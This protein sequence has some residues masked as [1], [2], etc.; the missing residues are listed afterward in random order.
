[1]PANELKPCP[2]CPD[3]KPEID[4]DFYGDYFIQCTCG[5]RG[6][7]SDNPCAAQELWNCR[8]GGSAREVEH[9]KAD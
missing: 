8:A 3:G 1:M 2:F 4:G 6:A 9:G 5:A 7:K